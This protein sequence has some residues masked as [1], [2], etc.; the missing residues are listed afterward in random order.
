MRYLL[1]LLYFTQFPFNITA[2]AILE[3]VLWEYLSK[4]IILSTLAAPSL[5][6]IK[7]FLASGGK[8]FKY[9]K[10]RMKQEKEWAKGRD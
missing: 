6:G 1:C 8:E 10:R 2:S 9:I 4:N 3:G 7:P 5:P